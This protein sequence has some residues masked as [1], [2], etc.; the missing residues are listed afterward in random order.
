MRVGF[1]VDVHRFSDEGTVRLCGVDVDG[2]RGVA[3]TSDG[4]VALHALIDALLGAAGV[5]DIGTH[6]PSSDPRW[7]GSDSAEL[8]AAAL[9]E[10]V[11]V[12]YA[13]SQVD[14]TIIA[15]TVRISPHRE[16]MRANLASLLNLRVDDVSVKATTTDGLGFLGTDEGI[17]A[18]AV[19]TIAER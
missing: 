8:L 12:G 7:A 17:A 13:P 18:T 1:G 16:A 19:A 11:S 5:G 15:E 10:I 14:V 6:F 9:A 2:T 4:D 3:A